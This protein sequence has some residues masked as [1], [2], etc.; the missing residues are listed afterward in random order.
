MR[1]NRA[2]RYWLCPRR[3][4]SKTHGSC[5]LWPLDREDDSRAIL[6]RRSK[7]VLS[8]VGSDEPI[9]GNIAPAV[10]VPLVARPCSLENFVVPGFVES[11]HC[12]EYLRMWRELID[13]ACV[14]FDIIPLFFA[15]A[16]WAGCNVAHASSAVD[17]IRS[18]DAAGERSADHISPRRENIMNGVD[19]IGKVDGTLSSNVDFLRIVQGDLLL[20]P[21]GDGSRKGVEMPP[22][23][24]NA[25][26]HVVP[27]RIA[28]L[29]A[30]QT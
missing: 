13:V 2:E 24:K 3:P 18:H 20:L 17:H 6:E 11:V 15:I 19:V 8:V 26:N 27:R 25:F 14:L 28:G 22:F 30:G 5:L 4:A 23:R 12:G 29:H 7:R 16:V 10:L 1:K 21:P 9:N